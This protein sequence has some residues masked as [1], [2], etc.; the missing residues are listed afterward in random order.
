MA[1]L[2]HPGAYGEHTMGAV[3]KETEVAARALGVQLQLVQAL[4]PNDFD[5]PF[6]TMTSEHAGTVIV[7]PSPML[8]GEHRRIVGLGAKR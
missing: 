3:L 6:S 1:A 5:S 2:W 8:F 7:L 4:G